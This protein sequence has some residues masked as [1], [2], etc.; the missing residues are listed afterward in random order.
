MSLEELAAFL[1]EG[2]GSGA[3]A[4]AMNSLDD[5]ARA[6]LALPLGRRRMREVERAVLAHALL[7]CNGNVSHAAQLLGVTRQA[8]QRRVR[9]SRGRAK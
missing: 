9:T 4:P 3:A 5:V 8:V 2:A 1:R 6:I 7:V